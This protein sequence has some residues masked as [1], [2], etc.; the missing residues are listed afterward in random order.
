MIAEQTLKLSQSQDSKEGGSDG[1]RTSEEEMQD[2]LMREQIFNLFKLILSKLTTVARRNNSSKVDFQKR[3][4][5]VTKM[6]ESD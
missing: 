5:K 6:L 1:K 4:D 2:I 3:I